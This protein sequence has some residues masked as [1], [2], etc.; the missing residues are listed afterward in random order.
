M[1]HVILI[2][3][4]GAIAALKPLAVGFSLCMRIFALLLFRGCRLKLLDF[5]RK[6]FFA[7]HGAY[8]QA[9]PTA[10]V[11]NAE[12]RDFALWGVGSLVTRSCNTLISYDITLSLFFQQ[13]LNN[14]GN[15]FCFFTVEF[16]DI[17]YKL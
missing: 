13:V 15:M 5:I 16:F 6:K 2:G 3:N 8:A 12:M 17:G 11:C 10:N 14:G 9:E 1:V 4:S 7:V